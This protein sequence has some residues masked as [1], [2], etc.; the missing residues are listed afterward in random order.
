[1][2]VTGTARCEPQHYPWAD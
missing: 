2:T 1:L